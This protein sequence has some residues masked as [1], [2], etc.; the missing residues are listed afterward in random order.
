MGA[1]PILSIIPDVEHR[2]VE[3]GL[4]N[5]KLTTRSQVH[6]FHVSF[7]NRSYVVTRRRAKKF[8]L[9]KSQKIRSIAEVDK[10][11][12]YSDQSGSGFSVHTDDMFKTCL[13]FILVGEKDGRVVAWFRSD[14]DTDV[15]VS[16]S[17]YSVIRSWFRRDGASQSRPSGP[18]NSSR[19]PL[20]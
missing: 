1:D 14:Q 11:V 12:V 17:I 15:A 18:L 2:I 13:R 7:V 3:T 8:V 5:L 16:R 9:S 10:V 19:T 6:V 4:S 20:S